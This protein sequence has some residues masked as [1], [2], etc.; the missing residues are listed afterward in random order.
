M[1]LGLTRLLLALAALGAA[2][3]P[4][5]AQ[6][7]AASLRAADAPLLRDLRAVHMGGHWAGNP[8]GIKVWRDAALIAGPTITAATATATVRRHRFPDAQG[9]EV[10]ND[11]VD[12][13]LT[14]V[15]LGS[16]RRL[17]TAGFW[18]VRDVASGTAYVQWWPSLNPDLAGI[19][20]FTRDVSLTLGADRT[21]GYW[22][23]AKSATGAAGELIAALLTHGAAVLAQTSFSVAADA[24]IDGGAAQA[25]M[26]A[27]HDVIRAHSR[28][29]VDWLHSMHAQWIG[30]SVAMFVDSVVDPTVRLHHPP[31]QPPT[32]IWTFD[33]EDLRGFVAYM[34]DAGF[35]VYLTLAF[36]I[37]SGNPAAAPDG[38][39]C[40]KPTFVPSRWLFGGHLLNPGIATDRCIDPALW[41]WH[42]EH[43]RHT[44]NVAAFF[45]SYRDVAVHYAR[46]AR[47]TGV[48]IYSLGTETDRLFRSRAGGGWPVHFGAQLR[49][50][51][52]AV[53]AEFPGVLTYDQHFSVLRQPAFFGDG[54]TYLFEDLDL[55]AVGVSAYFPL[56]APPPT[57]V[58]EPAEFDAAWTQ[59]FDRDLVP[60]AARNP[61]RPVLFTEV[62]YT[63]DLR[64]PGNPPAGEWGPIAGRDA[65]GVSDGMRQQQRAVESFMRVNARYGGLVRGGFWWDNGT[66]TG[67]SDA[68]CVFVSFGAYCKPLAQA[69]AAAYAELL[70]HDVD[71]VLDWA[72]A[73]NPQHFPGHAG[74]TSGAGY[75]YRHYPQTGNYV[76]VKN[77]RVAVHNGRDWIMLDVGAL[78][79]YLDQAARDGF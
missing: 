33:D 4:C 18:I 72:Q 48:E 53:R 63:D 29:T 43:P 70:R 19:E 26:Q 75:L 31:T 61:G 54:A 45:E 69:I 21:S 13:H 12:V 30:L 22:D 35:R 16:G 62:G 8:E 3:A 9:H 68:R 76:G 5:A 56:V 51:V 41:W 52:A 64:S 60:L 74:T 59:V 1:R 36:E 37:T 77:G 23:P 73:R 38:P 65:T 7:P 66:A 15:Q 25:I 17:A 24:G 32:G 55:D 58:L 49:S 47:E 57:H 14:D 78:G 46:L 11:T 39:D 67:P 42:P 71:R 50:M 44:A 10:V 40:G 34:R 6:G 79:P 20:G 2:L 27:L 28:R